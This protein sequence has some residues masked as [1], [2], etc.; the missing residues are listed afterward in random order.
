MIRDTVDFHH[1][2]ERQ[3]QIHERLLNWHR[4]GKDRP[5]GW[6]TAPMFRLYRTKRQHDTETVAIT[7]VDALDALAI[8]RA[9]SR[10]P[11]RHRDATRWYY[12]GQGGDVLGMCRRM[13]LSK[14][15]LAEVVPPC[16]WCAMRGRCW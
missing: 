16:C 12:F 14:D 15:G 3:A 8:E 13:G 1:V 2:P 7:P 5:H 10:L 11:V 6:A 4:W 9:V